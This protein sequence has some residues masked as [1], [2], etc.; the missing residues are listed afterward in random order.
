MSN[1]PLLPVSLLML[2]SVTAHA[3]CEVN[4]KYYKEGEVA[5]IS[6]Y[7]YTCHAYGVWSKS[8][9]HCAIQPAPAPAPSPAAAPSPDA[10]TAAK[11]P[12]QTA[13]D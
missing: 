6:R 5:C 9:K 11:P 7:E 4:H 10:A 8:A 1:H 2:A 3:D 12:G 13:R